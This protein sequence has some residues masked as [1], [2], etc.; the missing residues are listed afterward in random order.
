M[1]YR[2]E[3]ALICCLALGSQAPLCSQQFLPA[4]DRF[5]LTGVNLEFPE[6]CYIHNGQGGRVLDVTR[7]PSYISDH[8]VWKDGSHPDETTDALLDTYDWVVQKLK[9]AGGSSWNHHKAAYII[10]FPDGTYAVNQTIIHRGEPWI[11]EG[12]QHEALYGIRVYGQSRSNTVLKLA[13][14]AA[15]FSDRN[16]PRAVLA[17]TKH[18]Q[19]NSISMNGLQNLTIQT[20]SGNP[21]AVGVDFQGANFSFVRNIKVVSGDGEGYAGVRYPI[22]PTQGL[23]CDITVEGFDVGIDV[24]G[25]MVA[26]G[27]VFEYIT[28]K[29]Q[30]KMGFRGRITISPIRKLHVV[31]PSGPA[32][33]LT[34]NLGHLLLLD[35]KLE[36]VPVEYPAIALPAGCRS[37]YGRNIELTGELTQRCIAAGEETLY[38]GSLQGEFVAGPVSTL[39]DGQES[40]KPEPAGGGVTRSACG[41]AGQMDQC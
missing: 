27:P 33:E 21:G 41:S 14:N 7:L 15:G 9:E 13:D 8:D 24:V 39:Y 34:T 18:T 36:S 20:G 19:N 31:Y 29:D 10:Y 11:R 30:K 26:N 16:N 6:D 32:V 12:S 28:L 3:I 4:G 40:Q 37:F 23:H 17:F 25:G 38:E 5:P 1:G 35:S 2:K 22:W